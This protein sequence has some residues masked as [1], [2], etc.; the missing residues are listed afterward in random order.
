MPISFCKGLIPE[1]LDNNLDI[2]WA[3]E[4]VPGSFF[5]SEIFRSFAR[6]MDEWARADP[7]M[8]KYYGGESYLTKSHGQYH[9]AYFKSRYKIKGWRSPGPAYTASTTFRQGRSTTSK[10]IITGFTRT[11]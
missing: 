5:A 2:V 9:M 10:L 3:G 4:K 8:L 1:V 6:N 11:F 7:G